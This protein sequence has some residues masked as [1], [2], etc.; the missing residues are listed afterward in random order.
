MSWRVHLSDDA[1]YR[2]DVLADVLCIWLTANEATFF[3][4]ETGATLGTLSVNIPPTGLP[5][6][7]SDEWAAFLDNLRAPNQARLP[8]IRLPNLTVYQTDDGTRRLYDDGHGLTLSSAGKEVSLG[9]ADKLFVSLKMDRA[10][11]ITAALDERGQL[12]IY[13]RAV[14]LAAEKSIGLMCQD[15]YLPDVEIAD[16]GSAVYAS[17]GEQVVRTAQDG[18]VTKTLTVP[19]QVGQIACSRDGETLITTDSETGILRVYQGEHLRFTHQKFAV[20]LVAA[21]KQVQLLAD[22]PTPRLGVSALAVTN[23]G[24]IVFAMDGIVTVT[25]FKAMQAIEVGV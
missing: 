21:A 22:I 10:R 14:L 2:L 6:R 8:V 3:E 15:G 16:G 20:D 11:G 5:E 24:V 9:T 7:G 17:D 1:I 23:T 18:T 25:D 13:Q 4:L 19:Y 12:Y